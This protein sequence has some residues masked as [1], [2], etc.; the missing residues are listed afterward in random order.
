MNWPTRL[1]TSINN[2]AKKKNLFSPY[3]ENFMPA[4][5]DCK[6]KKINLK[7]VYKKLTQIGDIRLNKF[8]K[9]MRINSKSWRD[10]KILPEQEF[11]AIMKQYKNYRTIR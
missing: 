8:V 9:N 11:K 7:C 4:I 2:Y 6:A 1:T 5:T 3:P 10:K